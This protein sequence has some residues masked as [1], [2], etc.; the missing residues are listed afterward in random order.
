MKH[1]RL[2]ALLL[3]CLAVAGSF[4]TRHT[5]TAKQSTKPIPKTTQKIKRELADAKKVKY[6]L[7]KG[8][9]TIGSKMKQMDLVIVEPVVMQQSYIK[10]AQKQGTLVYGYINAMEADKWNKQL[11]RKFKATDFYK[12]KHGKRMYFKQ[13]DAYLMNMNSK[14]YQEVLLE[15][16]NKQV[17][18][19]GLD[20]VFL[21][22]VGD[23]DV[24]LPAKEQK[25]QNKAMQQFMKKIKQ[26]YNGVSLAQNWGFH[27]LSKYTAPYIDFVMWEDFS[28]RVVGKDEWSLQQMKNLKQ[29]RKQYGIQII[30]VGFKD[31]AKSRKLAEKNGFKYIHNA[32]GPYYNKW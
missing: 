27:T 9:K 23:I 14:H 7:N 28:Y 16:I 15:E 29:L 19:K 2:V 21:D 18:S 5:A 32:A 31:S 1:L 24:F 20:G 30:T 11:Y 17:V 6:Y 8:N 12:D 3:L 10:A 25:V 4:L 22:T 26:R 13:W